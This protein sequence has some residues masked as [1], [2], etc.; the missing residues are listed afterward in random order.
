MLHAVAAGP[1][2]VVGQK[3]VGVVLES[4]ELAEDGHR[5]AHDPFGVAREGI[6]VGV[7][8]VVMQRNAE[9]RRWSPTPAIRNAEGAQRV[10]R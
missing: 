1:R 10:R 6:G 2:Q 7:G 9:R 8:A 4:R 5:F 3:R